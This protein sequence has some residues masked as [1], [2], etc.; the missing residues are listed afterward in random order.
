MGAVRA[1]GLIDHEAVLGFLISA[2]Q[3]PD[4]GVRKVASEALTE[5]SSPAVARRLAGVLATPELQAQASDLLAKIGPSAV[6]L[7]ID[8]LLHSDPSMRP[9]VGQLIEQIVGLDRLAQRLRATEPETRWRAAIGVGTIGGPEAVDLLVAALA[10]PE[11]QVRTTAVEQLGDLGDPRAYEA[12][13]R[14]ATSDPVADVSAAAEQAIA[15]IT[16]AA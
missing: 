15:K 10:D 4:R 7:L 13:M 5:W 14:T 16:G 6:E 1:L 3:D 11:Q 2:L 8:V 12:V 9:M